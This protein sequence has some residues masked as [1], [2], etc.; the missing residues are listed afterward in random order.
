MAPLRWG[1]SGDLG[2]PAFL[3]EVTRDVRAS[4]LG[5]AE[6]AASAAAGVTVVPVLVVEG[7]PARPALSDADRAALAA[8]VA[9]A[10]ARAEWAVRGAG[11]LVV[12]AWGDDADALARAAS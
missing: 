6:A 2:V 11:D 8:L 7:E 1:T 4:P 10:D 3:G 5:L 9:Q 12:V